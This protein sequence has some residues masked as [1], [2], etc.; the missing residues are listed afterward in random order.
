MSNFLLEWKV[1]LAAQAYWPVFILS[2][3][4]FQDMVW[5]LVIGIFAVLVLWSLIWMVEF[6]PWGRNEKLC[7]VLHL[8]PHVEA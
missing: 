5:A 4:V 3:V 6:G 7:K 1:I 8:H 2:D